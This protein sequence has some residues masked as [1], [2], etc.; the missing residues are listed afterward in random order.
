[1]LVYNFATIAAQLFL[2]LYVGAPTAAADFIGSVVAAPTSPAV[3]RRLQ[4]AECVCSP[5]TY[6]FKLNFEGSCDDDTINGNPGISDTA[7]LDFINAPTN[8]EEVQFN[9]IEIL[10]LDN[11][12]T[13][14]Q[15]VPLDGPFIDGE[16]FEYTSISVGN[17]VPGGMQIILRGETLL[18]TVTVAWRYNLT[19]CDAEPIMRGDVIGMIEVVDYTSAIPAFCPA[20]VTE[21]PTESP[22]ESP[23][24][25][26]PESPTKSPVIIQVP[27]T[28]SPVDIQPPTGSPT[29][30]IVQSQKPTKSPV[31]IQPPTRS[32]TV[33]S[34]SYAASFSLVYHSKAAKGKAH[35][36]GKS[37]DGKLIRQRRV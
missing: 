31:I 13:L 27:P 35:K 26:Q 5:T 21:P 2:A 23:V 36:T 18:S 33:A 15:Q 34:M 29:T 14:A 7:C 9:R 17:E 19:N 10:E 8:A 1:M 16:S 11:S 30:E 3:N 6:T 20:V 28:K 4:Q 25:V 37:K 24:L 12:Q 32:P 22:S